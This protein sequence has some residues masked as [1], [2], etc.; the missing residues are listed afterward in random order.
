MPKSAKEILSDFGSQR[1]RQIADLA[2]SSF[3]VSD[4]LF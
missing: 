1:G 2:F 4:F 3:S